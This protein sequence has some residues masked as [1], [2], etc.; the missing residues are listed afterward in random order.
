MLV[1]AGSVYVGARVQQSGYSRGAIARID[2]PVQGGLSVRIDPIYV[3]P[4]DK[5]GRGDVNGAEMHGVAK[6]GQPVRGDGV[7]LSPGRAHHS[8]QLRASP[9][10]RDVQ[11]RK[12]VLLGN[13]VNISLAIQQ[14]RHGLGSS[15]RDGEVQ[16][17]RAL[18]PDLL[19]PRAGPTHQLHELVMPVRGRHV[20]RRTV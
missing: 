8:Q 17:R 16:R 14:D 9:L 12:P 6:H 4:A 3:R 10:R 18:R 19:D 15:K 7:Y 2:G 5:Q 1:P 11:G 20:Q 13:A